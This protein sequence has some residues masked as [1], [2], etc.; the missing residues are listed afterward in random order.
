MPV[1]MLAVPGAEQVAAFGVKCLAVA[2]GFL[3]GYALGG[4][5]AWGLDRWVFAKK[6]PDFVKKTI[7]LLTGIA[8]AILVALLVFGE[9]S[10]GGLFGGG[11]GSDGSGTGQPSNDP[12]KKSE[13]PTPPTPPDVKAPKVEAKTPA[14]SPEDPKVRVTFLGGEAVRGDRFYLLDNDPAPKTFEEL[15]AAVLKRKEGTTRPMFLLVQ[16]PA[17]PRQRIDENSINVTQVTS[18]AR[19]FAGIEVVWPGKK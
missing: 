14:I 8:A 1:P 11:R 18:W 13:Q 7:K 9:G 4:L 10:G 19:N 15:K 2:G 16:F 12:G 5:A 17:D 6:A 3:A